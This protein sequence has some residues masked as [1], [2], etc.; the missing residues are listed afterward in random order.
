MKSNNVN[1]YESVKGAKLNDDQMKPTDTKN[2][3][4]ALGDLGR[5]S[6]QLQ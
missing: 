5:M 4:D 3:Q 2:I 1:L 6:P